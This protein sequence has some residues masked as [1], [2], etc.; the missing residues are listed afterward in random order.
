MIKGIEQAIK[1]IR[2]Q[3]LRRQDVKIGS[4][5]TMD[6]AKL[7]TTERSIHPCV[8]T[9]ILKTTTECRRPRLVQTNTVKSIKIRIR[10]DYLES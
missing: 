3:N 6:R 5:S 7:L 2:I 8:A 10:F 4:T 9:P 1:T